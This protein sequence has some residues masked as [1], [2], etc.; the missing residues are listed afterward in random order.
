MKSY[1]AFIT[2]KMYKYKRKEGAGLEKSCRI[3]SPVVYA[4]LTEPRTW[5]GTLT[6]ALEDPP[7][8]ME[9][10][11]IKARNCMARLQGKHIEVEI[12]CEILTLLE[13]SHG[14]MRLFT[15]REVLK[16]RLSR[17]AFSAWPDNHD[18]ELMVNIQRL[19]WDGELKEKEIRINLLVF[20]SVMIMRYEI[21][22]V[23]LEASE[24]V[25]AGPPEV[26]ELLNQLQSEIIQAEGDKMELKRKLYRYEKDIQSLKKGI[27]RAESRN[28]TLNE[29][30]SRNRQIIE[31]LK[32]SRYEG[33]KRER[34]R[35]GRSEKGRGYPAW[36]EEQDESLSLGGLIKRLFQNNA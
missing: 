26:Q 11:K 23:P 36:N 15:R 13:N 17:D 10:I 2:N 25:A 33:D 24:Q 35:F 7:G 18:Q 30:L 19:S 14:Q 21:V 16:E 3:W 8:R 22:K 32:T 28:L 20:Y 5:K 27:N 6:Y 1:P 12:A 31:E 34:H 9:D 4:E 29:E